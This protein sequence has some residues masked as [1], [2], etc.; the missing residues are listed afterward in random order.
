MMETHWIDEVWRAPFQRAERS[1]ILL[2]EDV[3]QT[4]R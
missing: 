1:D 4:E 3:L 2:N